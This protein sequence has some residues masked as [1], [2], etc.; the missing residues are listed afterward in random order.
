MLNITLRFN[1]TQHKSNKEVWYKGYEITIPDKAEPTIESTDF[2]F[3]KIL[4]EIE[5]LARHNYFLDTNLLQKET[6]VF[7][8]NLSK[9]GDFHLAKIFAPV[10][11][12][13][14]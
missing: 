5:C 11:G 8:E 7:E 14:V 1:Q 9:C 12:S 10:F 4:I 2:L 6:T 3:I 13:S